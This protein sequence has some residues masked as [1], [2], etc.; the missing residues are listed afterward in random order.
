MVKLL[1]RDIAS[2]DRADPMFPFLRNFDPYAG[3]SWA[4]GHAKFGDGNN[5]ESSSEAMNAWCGLILWS[6]ATGDEALRDLGIYLY[7]TEMN[8]IQ[9]YWFDVHDENHPPA[10]TPAVVTMIWGGKGANATWFTDN[11]ESVHG[12]N[13][14]PI[15]GGSLYL[16]Q[17]PDYVRK[18]YDALVQENKGTSWDAWRDIIYMYRALS[19]PADAMKQ[20]DATKDRSRFEQGNSRANTYHWIGTLQKAGQVDRSVTADWPLYAVFEKEGVKTYAAFNPTDRPVTVTFS[21]ATKLRM[22]SQGSSATTSSPRR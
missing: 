20:F 17:Y 9:E 1:I 12:I 4:A 21:D 15:T 19:D 6:V 7:T 2:P 13:F 14:L 8:A 10:Y 5:N 3:H 16:G 22:T 18:N 11:P